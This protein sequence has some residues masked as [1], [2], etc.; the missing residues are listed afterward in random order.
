MFSTVMFALS[1]LA[2]AVTTNEI[3]RSYKDWGE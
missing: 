2:L 1:V 3:Y